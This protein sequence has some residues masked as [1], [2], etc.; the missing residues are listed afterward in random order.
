MADKLE[1]LISNPIVVLALAIFILWVSLQLIT[2]D[3][4]G[5]SF[6]FI[7]DAPESVSPNA[8]IPLDTT[9][10][11]GG[12]GMTAK[13]LWSWHYINPSNGEK[14]GSDSETSSSH[15]IAAYRTH[16]YSYK[17]N[18]VD[19][20]IPLKLYLTTRLHKHDNVDHIYYTQNDVV[21][22]VLVSQ[23]TTTTIVGVTTTTTIG[24]VT[25]TTQAHPTTTTLAPT[26]TTLPP[27]CP[28]DYNP[29]CGIDGVTYLNECVAEH[30]GVT[31][32]YGG[33]CVEVE[34]TWWENIIKLINDFI[35]W[36]LGG[37][38]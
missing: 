1:R 18:V 5:L 17:L 35:Q 22:V 6:N 26:P 25:T 33:E 38:K 12:S 36:I 34:L 20:N 11:M 30:L 21:D 24:G 15:Y 3:P 9:V 32:D 19:T 7:L 37:F 31:V 10:A 2:L 27:S 23:T 16:T 4:L 14:S 8:I 13:V 29:V 28:S